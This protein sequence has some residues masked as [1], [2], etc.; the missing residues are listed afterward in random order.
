MDPWKTRMAFRRVPDSP[1]FARLMNVM[2]SQR[3]H[4]PAATATAI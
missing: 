4:P 1:A 3:N 2:H